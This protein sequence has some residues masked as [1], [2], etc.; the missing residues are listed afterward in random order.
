MVKQAEL[1]F[2]KVLG[3][4]ASLFGGYSSFISN[5][6]SAS[7]FEEQG[8]LTRDDYFRQASLTR[9]QG[10]RIRAK[11]TMEYV[12]AGVELAGTPMLML[13]ETMS[14]ARAKARSQEITGINT[15]RL[16]NK[17]ADIQKE[18]GMSSLV[19]SILTGAAL[20]L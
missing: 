6:E 5:Y 9:E 10:D 4:G 18:E 13:K 3:A 8:A 19:S 7:L 14:K 11:Q 1:S 15:E 20:L 2:G 17:K 12:G 16:Y